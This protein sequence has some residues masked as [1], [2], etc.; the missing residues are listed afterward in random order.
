MI[1]VSIRSGPLDPILRGI[2]KR[3]SR[4]DTG[5]RAF[6]SPLR[7][8]GLV[9]HFNPDRSAFT[10]RG[11][12]MGTYE[13]GTVAV[14]RR[15]MGQGKTFV[16]LG[17]NIGYFSLI[18]A[19]AATAQGRVFAFEPD[20]DTFSILE[21]NIVAND[22]QAPIEAMQLAIADQE[23][24]STFHQYSNDAGSS[25]LIRRE[26]PIEDSIDVA[27]TTLDQWSKTRNWPKMDVVKMDI[28]GAEVAA[29]MGMREVSE[30]NRALKLLIEFNSAALKS[31]SSNREEFFSVLRSLGFS[32]FSIINDRSLG[33]LRS[34]R[35]WKRLFRRALWEPVNLLC[36]KSPDG[37]PMD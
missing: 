18:A 29:L 9:I 27:V 28:E 37:Q 14:V 23:G 1:P 11:L 22:L 36:E 15:L 3:A 24:R 32:R 21:R 19:R 2:Y 4:N 16:D 31:A 33:P 34:E 13:R 8:D 35:A 10:V 26:L 30:R 7:S 17:A 25:S 5:L 12:V 6:V 20:P